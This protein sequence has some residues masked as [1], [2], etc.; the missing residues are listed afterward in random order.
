LKIL[1]M[2][3][4]E[5]DA[6][7]YAL[8]MELRQDG[9]RYAFIDPKSKVVAYYNSIEFDTVDQEGLAAI[10]DNSAYFKYEFQS[11]LI[12]VSSARHTIVPDAIFNASN[13]KDIFKLN[14]TSPID[15]LDYRRLPELGLISIYEIPLWIKSVFVKR[16]LRSKINH[17]STVLLKGIFATSQYKPKA[18]LYKEHGL[19]YIAMTDK[20]KLIFFNLFES[21]ELADLVY[22]YLYSLEQKGFD[23]TQI[24]LTV[25]GLDEGD[26][27]YRQL[28]DLVS[29]PIELSKKTNQQNLFMLTNQL[30]CV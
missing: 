17:H 8:C 21:K 6:Y 23:A 26:E 12:S 2:V 27:V 3:P 7:K 28:K 9:F 15:N 29:S 5:A 11:V 13:P 20:N 22:Y 1:M 25:F 19:F 4:S 14:H 18:Y 30:L 16:F 10:L 24:V